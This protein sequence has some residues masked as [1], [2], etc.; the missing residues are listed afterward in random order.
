M[1]QALKSYLRAWIF[2]L[3]AQ[4]PI[5]SWYIIS[6]APVLIWLLKEQVLIDFEH[7]SYTLMMHKQ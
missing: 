6:V 1:K 3:S 4:I 2:H 5:S 7:W